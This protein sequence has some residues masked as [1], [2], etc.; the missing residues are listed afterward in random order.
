[1]S[2][3]ADDTGD[4]A[5]PSCGADDEQSDGDA[6]VFFRDLSGFLRLDTDEFEACAYEL[7]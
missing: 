6:D 3:E 4:E 7:G 1:M 2:G 5:E